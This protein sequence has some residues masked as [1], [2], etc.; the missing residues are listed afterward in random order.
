[1]VPPHLLIGNR[2]ELAHDRQWTKALLRGYQDPPIFGPLLAMIPHQLSTSVRVG[3][4]GTKVVDFEGSARFLPTK[5][6]ERSEA[7]SEFTEL[8]L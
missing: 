2:G 4:S 3:I 7:L 5:L 6:N 8:A 1:M